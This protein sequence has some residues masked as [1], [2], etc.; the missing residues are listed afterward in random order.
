VNQ[1]CSVELSSLYIDITKDRMYCDAP[2]GARRRATQSVIYRVFDRLTRLLAPILVF[3]ADEAW[4]Y[5]RKE[6]SIH[7][8][9]FPE[10]DSNQLDNEA[11]QDV[12]ALLRARDVVSRALETARQQKL[13]GN[14]LEAKVQ[15][16]LPADDRLHRLKLEDIEEFLILS[17]LD[18]SVGE[19]EPTAT[20]AKTERQRCERCWRHRTMVGAIAEHPTLCDRCAEV[21]DEITVRK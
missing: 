11:V 7:L 13:I 8:E 10:P 18:L 6:N 16:S 15:L 21:V 1:F 9:Q 5:F 14:N 20:A 19:G 3:T 2:N 17:H 12:E 4:G